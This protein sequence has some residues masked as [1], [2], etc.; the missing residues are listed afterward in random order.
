MAEREKAASM[1]GNC[2]AARSVY[3]STLYEVMAGRE[4]GDKREGWRTPEYSLLLSDR[5][6]FKEFESLKDCDGSNQPAFSLS[7]VLY[8]TSFHRKFQ[9]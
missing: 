9:R 2:H 6:D 7:V 1:M 3:G 5:S 4:K 8:E